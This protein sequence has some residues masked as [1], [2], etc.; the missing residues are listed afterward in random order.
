MTNLPPSWT[1]MRLEEIADV[2]GGIQKQGKR[3]PVKNKY[4]FL[5]VANVLRGRLN[6]NEVHEVE[7][8]AGELDRYKLHPGDLLVVEGNGSADQIGR[9]AV[10]DG[11]IKNCVHQNHLIRVRPFHVLPK[12]LEFAWNSPETARYI[13]QIAGST[14]G[15]Y[16]LSTTKVKA[17]RIPVPT[18][19]EQQRIVD[20]LEDDL[21][22]ID[23][24]AGLVASTERRLQALRR[25]ALNAV[26]NQRDRKKVQLRLLVERIEAGRS[27]GGAAPPASSEE[28]G[29]IKVSAMTW[30]VFKPAENKAVPADRADSR[31]EIRPGDLLMS[32]A[33]TSD[34]VGA[35]VLVG[36][37]RP[38]L[39]LSDKSL[40]IVPKDGIDRH[41]LWL[42]LSSPDARAQI[43]AKATGTKDSMRNVSQAGLL[44]V[45]VPHVPLADQKSDVVKLSTYLD[46]I[47][48]LSR[49]IDVGQRK[50]EALQHAILTAAFSG[51]LSWHDSDI[52]ILEELARV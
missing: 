18:L 42:A 43:S 29:I 24:A 30:G 9:A 39:L 1:W 14:S 26:I 16:T 41:W 52:E 20:T 45:E 37:V 51:R 17:V 6:L 4:P 40:R 7:L 48:Q 47:A 8:F 21:S 34:Y 50:R 32:R 22:R 23:A 5:R 38:R 19:D 33:N 49:A 3:R 36:A 10:W 31:Y 25:S 35:S 11:S 44:T 13:R 27:F 28:W 15:L 12:Y 46:S 2:H